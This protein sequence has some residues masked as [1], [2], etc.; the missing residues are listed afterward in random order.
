MPAR[1][2]SE[3]I[4]ICNI[5]C[6]LVGHE[7]VVCVFTKLGSRK[8]ERIRSQDFKIVFE[9]RAYFYLPTILAR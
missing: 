9:A 4:Y 1:V 5:M 8:S 2:D 6:M 3:S 7:K